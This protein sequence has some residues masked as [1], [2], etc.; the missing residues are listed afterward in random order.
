MQGTLL[1]QEQ[2]RTGAWHVTPASLYGQCKWTCIFGPATRHPKYAWPIDCFRRRRHRC[3]RRDRQH[4]LV[5]VRQPATQCGSLTATRLQRTHSAVLLQGSARRHRG[6]KCW[7]WY[8]PKSPLH[9]VVQGGGQAR[10][11]C[12]KVLTGSWERWDQLEIGA[13]SALDWRYRRI[14]SCR[15]HIPSVCSVHTVS[16]YERAVP[17]EKQVIVACA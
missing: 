5:A 6:H 7:I 10:R 12:R 4:I 15:Q 8:A 14:A 16:T 11:S 1:R 2:H 9:L 17:A 13:M 3:R